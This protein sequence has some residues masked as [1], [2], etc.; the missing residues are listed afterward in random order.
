MDDHRQN[1]GNEFAANSG[2]QQLPNQVHQF[3]GAYESL[4]NPDALSDAP[5]PSNR[6]I[7][8]AN[9]PKSKATPSSF[10]YIAVILLILFILGG[11]GALLGLNSKQARDKLASQFNTVS[12]PLAD[13]VNGSSGSEL[14]LQ[15][16]VINGSLL[17]NGDFFIAPTPQPDNAKPGQLYYDQTTNQ[18]MYYNGEQFIALGTGG[19]PGVQNIGGLNGQVDLGTGL[20]A[21]NNLL[22]NSGVISLQGQTGEVTL[23][24]GPGIAIDG[25]TITNT[26]AL[27]LASGSPNITV[28][29][30][31]SGNYSI[32]SSTGGGTVTSSGGNAGAIPLFTASQNIEDSIITQ[33]GVTVTINGDL[34]VVTGGLSLSN[35]LTVSNGGTGTTSLTANGVLIGNGTAPLSAVATSTPN[36]CLLSSAGAPTWGACPGGGGGSGVSSLNGLTGALSLANA[37]GAGSTITIDNASTS[38][39][40]IASFDGANFSVTGGAVNTIQNIGTTATPTFAGVN[41]NT[42]TPAT[43]LAV[44]GQL[45]VQGASATVGTGSLQ[46]SLTLHAGNGFAG[47][48]QTAA[49]G[50]NRTYILPDQDGTLCLNT[51]NCVGSGGS[52]GGAGTQDRL[53]KFTTTGSTI[54]DSSISDNGSIVT[55]NGSADLIVQGGNVTVGVGS[56]QTGAITL[57]NGTNSNTVTLQSGAT[58]TSYTLTLPT[59]VGNTSQ[60]L[61]AQNGTGALFWDDCLGGGGGG[62]IS[63]IN[64]QTGPAITI[65][66]ATASSNAITINN[67]AAD[68]TSKGIAAFNSTN[69]TDGGNGVINTVQNISTA[70]SPQFAGLTLTGNLDM[71]TN[72]IQGTTATIDFTNFDVDGSGNVSAAGNMNLGV[73]GQ[74]QI[75]GVQISSAAL[76]N[77]ANLA[78]LNATQTFTGNNNTFRN[79]ANSAN[80]FAVQNAAG[81]GILTVNTSDGQVVLGSGGALDGKLVFNN[82]SNTNTVTLVPGTPSDNRTITLPDDSGIVCLNTGNCAGAGA[83]LQTA[84]NFSTGGTTP[85]IKVNDTL[86]G[87][88]IQD[89]D[90][91]IGANLFNIRASDAT[92]LGAV[93]FGVG[94]TGQVT[95]QNSANSTTAFRLL[96]QGGTSVIT[97]DTINGEVRLGQGGTL[98]GELVFQNAVNANAISLVSATAGGNRIIT[99]PD[100]T[101]IVCLNTG[102]CT[103]AGAAGGDLTGSYPNP[104]IAKLQGGTLTITTPTSGNILQYNGTAWVNQSISGDI[105]LDSSG[106]ATIQNNAVTSA[107]IADGTIVNADL[108]GGAYTSITSVGTLTGLTVVGPTNINTTGTANTAIGNATGTFQLTSPGLNVSTGGALTGVTGITTSGGYTQSGATANVFTGATSFTGAGTALSVTN[109]ATIGGQL[110]VNTITPNSALTIGATNQTFTLQGNATS[111]LTATDGANTTT[112]GFTTP[113]ADTTI[114]LP[115]LPAGTYTICTSNGNCPSVASSLQSAYDN[116]TTPEIVLD[117][118]RG[119]LTIRDATSPLVGNL[120]EV[121]NNTG[122]T[123]YFNVTNAGINVTGGITNSGDVNTTGGDIQTAGVDRLTNSGNL[124]NIGTITTSGAINGQTISNAANFTGTMTIQGSN[125]LTLGTASTNTGAILFKG[126]GGAGTLTLS[127]PAAPGNFTLSIPAITANAN[128]CTDNSICAGYAPATGSTNYANTALSNLTGVAINTTLLPGAAGAIN[129]GSTA[130][131]FGDLFLSGTSSAPGTNNFRLTGIST[132]GTRTITLPDAPGTVCLQSSASCGFATGSGAAFVQGGNSFGAPAVLGTND[133]NSLSFETGGLTQ[134]TIAVG[135]ATTFQNTTNS[136]SALRVLNAAAAP[137][138][139]VNTINPQV[140]VNSQLAGSQGFEGVTF[141]PTSPGTWTT[142]GNVGWSRSTTVFQ[143]GAASAASG[144]IGNSQSSYL[145]FDYTFASSG[146]LLFYWRVDSETFIDELF[147]CVDNDACTAASSY[148][149]ISGNQTWAEVVVPVA[150][151]AHSFRWV[152][153]KDGSDTVGADKGWID[154]VRVYEGGILVASS[155]GTSSSQHFNLVQGGSTK[156]SIT[157]SSFTLATNIDLIL[158]GPSA[159]ISNSQGFDRSEVFGLGATVTDNDAVVIGADAS[160]GLGGTAVGY[161]ANASGADSVALGDAASATDTY[162]VALGSFSDANFRGSIALGVSAATTATNQLVIGSNN[163]EISSVRIG[164][165][166]TNAAPI[167]FTLQGTSGTG[168]NIAGAS[169]NIAGGQSTGNAAGGSL[170]FQVSAAGT[171]G[172]ATNALS[173]VASL[174]GSNGA[175][176]F[177]NATNS[178]TAFRVL[179]ATSVPQFVI[180]TSNSRVYIGNPTADGV[181]GLLVLDTKNTTGDPVSGSSVNGAMYYNSADGKFRCYQNNEWRDCVSSVTTSGISNAAAPGTTTSASYANIPGTSSVAFTKKAASTK[182]TVT[183]HISLWS[184]T[185]GS[186][187]GFGVL[188]DGTDYNC[189]QFFFNTTNEHHSASCSVVVTGLSAGSK[190]VQGRWKVNVAAPTLQMDANDWTSIVV[191]ETD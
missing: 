28:S 147:L 84:Y 177:Q 158:Q 150:A 117:A 68:G 79:G 175:A 29:N 187:A 127:G 4:E 9:S 157:D 131:P 114:N 135:G 60:C 151:G 44:G 149:V 59:T 185:V 128:I 14:G 55:L 54:G 141:P 118:T 52:V 75:N 31:G 62:S 160:A 40:G 159:Y 144:T 23:T 167:G 35:P 43:V 110:T 37:S 2:K 11:L 12:V 97:G 47:T 15:S 123:T 34:A 174:S 78:K 133:S 102:N 139:T 85:K 154:N 65:N 70:A 22:I 183:M 30:D 51:G 36:L 6:Y 13:F 10:K 112:F 190:T 92:G 1:T 138:L 98:G 77:D 26:G 49:L 38:S 76:S 5:Q 107:K 64:G 120:L 46:G 53:A 58:G 17:L 104:T 111:T 89:A 8:E 24:G 166:V 134:A 82:V 16:V 99:L 103:A 152:Y 115:A 173:T 169:I 7:F 143:E 66:N 21:S 181:A 73:G 145:D 91:T 148:A 95:L 170:N 105:V 116:S 164:N 72:A 178:P 19:T 165:G 125:A 33:S 180:D 80:A 129:L 90:T 57:Q 41:T 136:A 140:E 142:G 155:V 83:T 100:A 171:S 94:N 132:G 191:T 137:V 3:N 176:T 101:G 45:A 32:S 67:A 86:L 39:K 20:T 168:T 121:Q 18:L 113:L 93:M 61:K 42:I 69:F 146:Q 88:D 161:F 96:T 172:T 71:G 186:A 81:T 56:S 124:I 122:S 163:E 48:I 87:V 130:F 184:N 162:A 74:Y 153:A 63:S 188:I 126:A 108:A 25:T 156:A 109:N 50:A 182:L 179:N 189:G 106:V 27:S 119:A